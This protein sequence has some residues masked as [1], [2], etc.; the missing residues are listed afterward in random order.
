MK[1][2]ELMVNKAIEDG[3]ISPDQKAWALDYARKDFAG[4]QVFVGKA[5]AA[6]DVPERYLS[7]SPVHEVDEVQQLINKMCGVD[8][9]T[10]QTYSPDAVIR[11]NKSQENGSEIDETQRMIN[12][13]FGIDDET[14][15]KYGPS[16]SKA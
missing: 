8:D 7:D 13:L 12:A 3:K 5:H 15:R 4:F 6:P 14:F 16:G 10:F 2:E 9:E 11:A 1:A